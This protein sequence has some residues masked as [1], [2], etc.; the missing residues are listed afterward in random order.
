MVD[1]DLRR[2]ERAAAEGDE[3]AALRLAALRS[4][5][6]GI[7]PYQKA[8]I[9]RWGDVSTVHKG[10]V[11]VPRTLVRD[12]PQKHTIVVDWTGPK[13]WRK[14]V[15]MAVVPRRWWEAK[16]AR[17]DQARRRKEEVRLAKSLGV[18]YQRLRKRSADRP[19]L[20]E[21][22]GL[23]VAR[24]EERARQVQEAADAL[25]RRIREDAEARARE[26]AARQRLERMAIATRDGDAAA[27]VGVAT[28]DEILAALGRALRDRSPDEWRA[29]ASLSRSTALIDAAD[30][31]GPEGD[32]QTIQRRLLSLLG[33]EPSPLLLEE[34]GVRISTNRESLAEFLERAA[35]RTPSRRGA[36]VRTA[37]GREVGFTT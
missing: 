18:T 16:R 4:R 32:A 26:D 21:R 30:R 11:K 25:A 3:A 12:A 2:L 35:G 36:Q 24:R 19:G 8:D 31:S 28:L 33:L 6:E 34:S 9:D 27:F 20:L 37:S 5:V 10:W 1:E 13:K 29:T 14:P 15:K 7:V 22:V 17:L 23:L